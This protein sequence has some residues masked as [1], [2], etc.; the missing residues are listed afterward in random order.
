MMNDHPR[1]DPRKPL[2]IVDVDEVLALFV[3]GFAR[4]ITP[5][6]YDFRLDKFALFENIYRRGDTEHLDLVSGRTLLDDFYRFASEDVD[7]APDAAHA[8]RR[9]AHG[10]ASVVILTNAPDHAREPRARWLAHHGMDFPLI[11]NHGLKGPPVASL[12]AQTTGT[13]AFVDDLLTNLDSVA[14]CAPRVHRFQLIADERLRPIAPTDPDRHR[15]IDH[16]PALS[17]ALEAALGL[18][19]P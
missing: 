14:E 4:H 16:W 19:P 12:A 2:L 6:G 10:G 15:R 11:I 13:V 7:P 3:H 17:D 18:S 8:L 1:V 9:I 5:Q